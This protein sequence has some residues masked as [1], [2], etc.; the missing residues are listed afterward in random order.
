MLIGSSNPSESVRVGMFPA[1]Y[2]LFFNATDGFLIKMS[3][4][5]LDTSTWRV[6]DSAISLMCK[7]R[8]APKTELLTYTSKSRMHYWFTG[9][10]Q[11]MESPKRSAEFLNWCKSCVEGTDTIDSTAKTDRD[12]TL[13]VSDDVGRSRLSVRVEAPP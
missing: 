4:V 6:G 9:V 11:C 5:C 12:Q 2:Q 13:D 1:K 3:S 10:P 7:L 8:D